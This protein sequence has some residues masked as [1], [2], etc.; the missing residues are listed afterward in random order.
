[1]KQGIEITDYHT[2]SYTAYV[3]RDFQLTGDSFEK[4]M[5]FLMNE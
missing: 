5:K 3:I 2:G 1:M 4:Y